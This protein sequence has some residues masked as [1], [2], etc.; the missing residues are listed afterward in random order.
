MSDW[1]SYLVPVISVHGEECRVGMTNHSHIRTVGRIWVGE[2]KE[3]G[4]LD[5]GHDV[6]RSV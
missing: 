3:R 4:V 5:A 2:Y 6:S 1:S